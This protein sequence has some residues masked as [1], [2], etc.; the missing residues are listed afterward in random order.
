VLV[1]SAS[2]VVSFALPSPETSSRQS[3]ARISSKRAAKLLVA[4]SRRVARLSPSLTLSRSAEYRSAALAF[5]EYL[6]A[7][8]D[9][10]ALLEAEALLER[11]FHSFNTICVTNSGALWHFGRGVIGAARLEEARRQTTTVMVSAARVR[12]V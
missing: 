6:A 5:F 7:G 1:L 2:R 9:R 3:H 10:Y 4:P 8:S 12:P 11:R